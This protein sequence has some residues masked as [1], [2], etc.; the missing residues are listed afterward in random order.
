MAPT[1]SVGQQPA[2]TTDEVYISN[3]SVD[4]AKC[5]QRIATK[6]RFADV[7]SNSASWRGKCVAVESYWKERTL[8]VT[9]V[10]VS[11][12]DAHSLQGQLGLYGKDALFKAAPKYPRAYV[13]IGMVGDC[14]RLWDTG[15][16]VMGYCHYHASG[17]Y[18][19]LAKITRR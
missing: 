4:P 19:A 7:V 15:A 10:A 18:L 3:I 1:L 11:A 9:K 6:V 16:I 14:E 13:A 2:S 5:N 12:P 17:P 8:F